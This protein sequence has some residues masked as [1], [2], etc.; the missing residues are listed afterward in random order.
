MPR[1][2]QMLYP[3][4]LYHYGRRGM[5]WYQHIFGKVQSARATRKQKKE[6]D[7]RYKSR[8]KQSK[9][10]IR[11]MSDDEIKSAMDRLTLE[12]Q[13]KEMIRD[14]KKLDNQ[15]KSA[16]RQ[17]LEE[18]TRDSSKSA[19]KEIGTQILK[20]AGTAGGNA[21]LK[22]ILKKQNFDDDQIEKYMK[23]L[24]LF[25]NNEKKK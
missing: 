14:S 10:D 5:K 24:K 11:R 25:T 18:V 20:S 16:G 6:E 8:M 15:N 17:W 21:A 12:K 13:Y 3:D 23:E 22:K 2:I 4:E 1:E 7:A 9:K 19:A